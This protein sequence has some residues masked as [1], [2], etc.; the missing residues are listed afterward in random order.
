[1][2][3]LSTSPEFSFLYRYLQFTFFIFVQ[4]NL[5]NPY[6]CLSNNT[7]IGLPE[8]FSIYFQTMDVK[9][10]LKRKL[11][12]IG[13]CFATALDGC[14]GSEDAALRTPYT[15]NTASRGVLF[16]SQSQ[17]NQFVREANR[18]GLQISLHAV[19]DEVILSRSLRL[20]RRFS[21]TV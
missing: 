2:L 21:R 10:V 13:G 9:K 7:T 15:N 11:P 3:S 5:C 12:R 4:E 20:G 18:K 14:F 19:G 8:E 17:V 1:M 6:R 16:Y